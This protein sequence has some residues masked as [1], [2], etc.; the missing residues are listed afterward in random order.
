[1]SEGFK[2]KAIFASAPKT[3]RGKPV[4]IKADAKGKRLLYTNGT[5]VFIRN[6]DNPSECDT[7]AEHSKEASV[8]AYAP[9]GNY[10][11]SGDFGGKIRIWDALGSEHIL[12]YEYTVLGGA[13]KDIAWT[14]DSK[15][16]VVGGEGREKF[17]HAFMWDTGTS[18]G[19]LTGMSKSVNNID[20]KQTRPYRCVTASEDY[21]V[22][23]FEGPPFKYK[24]SK[25]EHSNFVNC[26]R[27]APDGSVF[28][29]AG[30][31]GK[32]FVY[33]GKTGQFVGQMNDSE[34]R[35]HKGGVYSMAFS[36]DSKQLL[37]VS[38]DK[39]AKI[40]NVQKRLL[41]VEFNF[42]DKLDHQQLGCVWAGDHIITVS[43]NGNINYL[44]K[45][46]PSAPS[47][48]VQGHNKAIMSIAVSEDG[49][50]IFSASYEGFIFHW[51]ARTGAG[52]K[53]SGKPHTNQVNSMGISGNYLISCGMDDTVRFVNVPG[54]E[55]LD[56]SIGM[57]SQP[58]ALS[59]GKDG[60][61]VVA[62]IKEIVII[63]NHRIVHKE[64]VDYEPSAIALSPSNTVVAVGSSGP[65]PLISYD[66]EHDVLKNKKDNGGNGQI[67]SLR[68]S[69]DGT[70]LA[71]TDALK[72]VRLFKPH[73]QGGFREVNCWGYHAARVNN[74]A[75]SPN[76]RLLATCSV[77]S[78]VNVWDIEK[79]YII[80]KMKAIHGLAVNIT[81]VGW[82]NNNTL[83]T[84]G[85][86]DCS[87]K[88]WDIPM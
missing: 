15:R 26:V 22:C 55:F 5:T 1:M 21:S 41:D 83:V 19:T 60:L 68:F 48:V 37:T 10:I 36:P 58:K 65:N 29:S 42:P 32:C 11:A 84:A 87:I 66:L 12:K 50:S 77:D 20:V 69:K 49:E 52:T 28:A 63:R 78:Y 31:D 16:I 51:D 62:C 27:Y 73:S 35:V 57:D 34:G 53:I 18:V 25:K 23:Y 4:V 6:L 8:A 7:Y 44:N 33:D 74:A 86:Q 47:K 38:A 75:F 61:V 76:G 9:T 39:T 14:E 80:H 64:S 71:S 24:D 2:L 46:N 45:D 17:A 72:S 56:E 59:V 40:W 79:G 43:L 3:T 70:Y 67:T 88:L 82:L 54:K 30:A 81:C 13:I 85:Q